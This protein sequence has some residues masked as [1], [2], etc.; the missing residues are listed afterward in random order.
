MRPSEAPP[1]LLAGTLW[2]CWIVSGQAGE[3]YEWRSEDGR[4]Q[5]GRNPQNIRV[6]WAAA[7]GKQ[8]GMHHGSLK[9]AMHAAMRAR[10]REA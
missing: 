1:F 6:F 7:D 9:Q 8:A 2:R 5:A 10:G 3:R 4:L